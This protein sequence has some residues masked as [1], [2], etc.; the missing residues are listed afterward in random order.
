MLV[1]IVGVGGNRIRKEHLEGGEME[2][3]H[4]QKV[5]DGSTLIW[6]QLWL[7]DISIRIVNV[8]VNS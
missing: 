5:K 2:W 4:D 6:K 3:N 7:I 8:L 1:V